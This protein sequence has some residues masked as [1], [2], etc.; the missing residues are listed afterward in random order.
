VLEQR[1]ASFFRDLAAATAADEATTAAALGE[2]VSMGLVTSDGFGGV[3]ALIR[4]S[5]R[6]PV[7]RDTHASAGRWSRLAQ[8]QQPD[9][10]R[11]EAL[12]IQARTLLGRYG[13]VFRKMV[14]REN[15]APWRDLSRVYRRLEA[16]GEIRGGRFVG[17]VSG[18]QFALPDA[19]ERLR[20][21]RRSPASARTVVMSAADPLNLTGLVIAGERVRAVVSTR[22]LFR[23]GAPV[24]ALEG[25]RVRR[26]TPAGDRLEADELAALTGHRIP[27]AGFGAGSATITP[28]GGQHGFHKSA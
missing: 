6:R 17:G 28:V 19:V 20:E 3:R 22:I 10:D 9:G 26:L 7:G 24:A 13:V 11:D 5:T 8:E 21:V 12:E 1:G 23:D 15:V 2:L 4:A 14:A 16:R 27:I 18:E 25:G